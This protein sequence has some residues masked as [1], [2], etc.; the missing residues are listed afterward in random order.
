MEKQ[1]ILSVHFTLNRYFTALL[2]PDKLVARDTSRNAM[3][4][5]APTFC[6]AQQLHGRSTAALR[7]CSRAA[8]AR[9]AAPA[10][11]GLV[12]KLSSEELEVALAERDRPLVIDFFASAWRRAAQTTREP[13][14]AAASERRLGCV[15][16]AAHAR[17]SKPGA[18]RASCLR[19]SWRRWPPPSEK[20]WEG[21]AHGLAFA[22]SRES[23]TRRARGQG[24]RR[25]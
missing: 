2:S 7:S 21:E 23:L 11:A 20:A 13:R 19:R 17:R 3:L 5:R 10:R 8:V 4:L 25:H 18:D 16:S 1:Y 24:R 6:G 22:G 15:G 9:R 12:Q 14:G